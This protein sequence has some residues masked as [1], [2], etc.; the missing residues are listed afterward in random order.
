MLLHVAATPIPL[1]PPTQMINVTTYYYH[2][3]CYY[4][5]HPPQYNDNNVA[6]VAA[7]TNYHCV[8]ILVTIILISNGHL[9]HCDCHALALVNTNV[10]VVM[11]KYISQN[12]TFRLA[13]VVFIQ[14]LVACCYCCLYLIVKPRCC[15]SQVNVHD[16]I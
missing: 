1:P 8:T 13:S 5:Y 11:N 4:S 2:I 7:T 10:A 9:A 15:N 14:L 6:V 12:C 3:T 16:L